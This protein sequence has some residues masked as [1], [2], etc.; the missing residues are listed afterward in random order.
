MAPLRI[1]LLLS[2]MFAPLIGCGKGG[3][4]RIDPQNAALVQRGA[5]VYQERCAICHGANLEGQPNWRERK[6]N[7]RL[8]APPHDQSG[9]TWHH[10]N[11]MLVEIVKQGLVP[12][13]APDGY[14]S[15]MPAF[16]SQLSDADIGAVLS[17]IQSRWPE[18]VRKFRREN[19]LDES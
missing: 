12:P 1:I 19:R 17:F 3:A 8:P 4:A 16:A 15:D 2:I 18:E 11:A 7:G 5:V 14:Q 6:P 9:H 13:N 10:P